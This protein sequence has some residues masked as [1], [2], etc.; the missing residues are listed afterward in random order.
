MPAVELIDMT[1][2]FAERRNRSIFSW[3]L[4]E[5][6]EATLAAG[7]QALLFV[8]RRGHS[9]YV[10][11]R[12]CGFVMVCHQCSVSLTFHQ[13]ANR[14][15]CHQCGYEVAV[16]EACPSC[17]SKA[18]RFAGLGT[19]K[20]E[21]ELAMNFPGVRAA[22]MDSDTTAVRGSHQ[23]FFEDFASGR[24]QVLVGTQMVAKGFNFPCLDL[25]GVVNA[26]TSLRLPDF[27][28]AERTFQL[29]TQVAGRVGRAE[30]PGRVLVQTFSPDHPALQRA[31]HHDY[32]GFA[33][34]ELPV[35]EQLFYPPFSVL[36]LACAEAADEAE[37]R[38]TLRKLGEALT[39]ALEGHGRH[40]LLGPAR[41]PVARIRGQHRFQLLLKLDPASDAPAAARRVL[42][43]WQPP[44]SVAT[45]LDVDP[46][47]LF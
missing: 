13:A 11:C 22:R 21:E 38:E 24:T 34:E 1:A 35:R 14:C 7:R 16:P 33:A 19:Q 46:I 37:S 39:A 12:A 36:V 32:D 20:V 44:S 15:R 9:T 10:F 6:L 18:F 42:A 8:N 28:A 3:A 25:V 17:A 40:Q 47:S 27:R 30:R 43:A 4:K 5:S 45:R 23:R 41:A 26:D 2:E 29:V 31:S